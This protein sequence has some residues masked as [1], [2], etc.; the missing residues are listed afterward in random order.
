MSS[1]RVE[2]LLV[3]KDLVVVNLVWKVVG[4]SGNGSGGGEGVLKAKSSGVI[5]ESN[6]DELILEAIEE[7]EDVP[8]ADGVLNGPLSAFGDIALE[9]K[10]KNM[11]WKCLRLKMNEE[12]DDLKI[13][14]WLLIFNSISS[15]LHHSSTVT[16]NYVG[17][18]VFGKLPAI[19]GFDISLP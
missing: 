10:F 8:L 6:G 14:L 18:V 13:I 9:F 7:E 16:Y 4:A 2:R 15:S 17:F 5:G 11:P 3:R 1:L 19:N 12:D